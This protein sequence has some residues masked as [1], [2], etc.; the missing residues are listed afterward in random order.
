MFC[1]F[2]FFEIIISISILYSYLLVRELVRELDLYYSRGCII[3]KSYD[4]IKTFYFWR[5]IFV[6]ESTFP[7]VNLYSIYTETLLNISVYRSDKFIALLR[8]NLMHGQFGRTSL[9]FCF[10]LIIPNITSDRSHRIHRVKI[11]FWNFDIIFF[12]FFFSDKYCKLNLY[13]TIINRLLFVRQ[14]SFARNLYF[15]NTSAEMHFS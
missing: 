3:V 5:E 2:F 14:A 13:C 4:C 11:Y 12:F 6:Y 7:A 8:F 15:E 10:S 1:V 9:S